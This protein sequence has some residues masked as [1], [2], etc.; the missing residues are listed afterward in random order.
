MFSKLFCLIPL[1]AP[2]KIMHIGV[3]ISL[4]VQLSLRLEQH[5]ASGSS[6]DAGC[7]ELHGPD[8]LLVVE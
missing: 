1:M 7:A 3:F 4:E 6:R 2:A 5:S 8:W